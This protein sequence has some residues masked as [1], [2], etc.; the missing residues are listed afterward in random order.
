MK[1]PHKTL[2]A[3]TLTALL[4]GCDD[5]ALVDPQKQIGPNPELPQAQNFFM[6]PMQ[7]RKARRGKRAK[8]QK[9]L[10]G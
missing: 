8:C 7:C 6:P 9:W 2:L 4:A 1:I 5:G 3:L 10:T